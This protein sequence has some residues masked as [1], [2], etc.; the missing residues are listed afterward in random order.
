M[1]NTP[2][3]THPLTNSN[4]MPTEP[5]E[6]IQAAISYWGDVVIEARSKRVT[7]AFPAAEKT[8]TVEQAAS[9]LERFRREREARALRPKTANKLTLALATS[10]LEKVMRVETKR[11]A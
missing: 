10:D 2:Y 4:V 8:T 9:R 1:S 6:I 11:A 5:L 3:W 7:K